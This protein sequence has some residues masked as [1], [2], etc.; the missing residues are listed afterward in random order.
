VTTEV[1]EYDAPCDLCPNIA[2][3]YTEEEYNVL[4]LDG[5]EPF[6]EIVLDGETTTLQDLC[7]NCRAFVRDRI[8]ALLTPLTLGRRFTAKT[9]D[10]KTE[11]VNH[12]E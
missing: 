7:P 9:D 11:P 12:D 8:E 10:A 2:A 6:A 4:D 5:R 3:T 1:I